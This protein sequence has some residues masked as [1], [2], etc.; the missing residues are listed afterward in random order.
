MPG[1]ELQGVGHFG[2][3]LRGGAAARLG[4]WEAVIENA[5]VSASRGQVLR[6]VEV[7]LAVCLDRLGLDAGAIA[8][9]VVEL[10]Q[11]EHLAD[12]RRHRGVHQHGRNGVGVGGDPVIAVVPGAVAHVLHCGHRLSLGL[13]RGELA[14]L[15]LLVVVVDDAQRGL[16]RVAQHHFALGED[17]GLQPADVQQGD[18]RHAG[19]EQRGEQHQAAADVERKASF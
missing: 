10:G 6:G 7:H 9:G 18:G 17:G 13:L 2:K 11:I 5:A 3:C 14:A 16:R 1:G 12:Q 15:R 4:L 8:G 19:D